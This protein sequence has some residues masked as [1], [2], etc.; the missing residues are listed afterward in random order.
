MIFFFKKKSSSNNL[1]NVQRLTNNLTQTGFK[2]K[3][4]SDRSRASWLF[5][6]SLPP[7]IPYITPKLNF[8]LLLSLSQAAKSLLFL[9]GCC[10][11]AASSTPILTSFQSRFVH[12]HDHDHL[13]WFSLYGMLSCCLVIQWCIWCYVLCDFVRCALIDW[14][15]WV[16]MFVMICLWVWGALL[17]Y[18]ILY[19][20]LILL[21]LDDWCCWCDWKF[22]IW[23]G[24]Q[25]NRAGY[26]VKVSL[27]FFFFLSINV[28]IMVLAICA[29]V[30]V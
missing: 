30:I 1:T 19:C 28:L 20:P 15:F 14:V 11:A 9:S 4:G 23:W 29:S 21:V 3:P 6:E 22:K 24:K 10:H 13:F 8:F 12:D 25:D 26:C 5:P 2:I 27:S 18:L 16:L 17:F 7:S